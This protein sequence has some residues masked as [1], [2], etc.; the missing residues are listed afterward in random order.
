[1]SEKRAEEFKRDA[2]RMDSQRPNETQPRNTRLAN[3][4]K[5]APARPLGSIHQRDRGSQYCS[6]DN[7]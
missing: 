2:G 3:G 4:A 7:Q 5:P 1:M 6:Q